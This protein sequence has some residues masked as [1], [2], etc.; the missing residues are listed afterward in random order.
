MWIP[1]L[2]VTL[3]IIGG[4]AALIVWL[5]RSAGSSNRPQSG[6]DAAERDPARRILEE[7]LARG[8]ITP[9]QFRELLATLKE[10]RSR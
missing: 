4:I 10:N 1:G 9:D 2:F 7:R 3:V 5:L 6:P 8:D